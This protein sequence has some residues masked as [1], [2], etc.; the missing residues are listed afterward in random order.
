MVALPC[1]SATIDPF[2]Y[3][4]MP[5]II[6][7]DAKEFA[8][9]TFA[10]VVAAT[11]NLFPEGD[12]RAVKGS[13][14]PGWHW[15]E[16]NADG[17][18]TKPEFAERLFT[19]T[20]D[21]SHFE[22]Q[23]HNVLAM[24]A[25]DAARDG[26][27]VV[28]IV[29]NVDVNDAG[30]TQFMAALARGMQRGCEIGRFALLNGETA[31]L[32]YR[33][34]GIGKNRLNWNAV[35]LKLVNDEKVIDGNGLKPG[36]PVVALRETSIRSNGLT[37]ARAILERAHM[38]Q[39]EGTAD[40][41]IYIAETMRRNLGYALPE[42]RILQVL[43]NTPVGA[44][45]WEHIHLPWHRSFPDLTQKLSQPST[46][47]TPLIYEAQGG[48]DGERKIP[49]VACAHISGGGVP[50]KGK[51]MV[52]GKELGIHLEAVFPDPEGISELMA[53]A[54]KGAKHEERPL[55]DERSACEQWNRGIGFLCVTE[56]ME[57]AK[58]LLELAARMGYEAAVAGE[59]TTTRSI[60]WRGQQWTY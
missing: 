16:V 37:R 53:L 43:D 31:E 18:G 56:N 41:R 5:E 12:Y 50:L 24:V 23:A 33:T 52:E 17:I 25:D 13:V 21:Y 8:S 55:I 60:E 46:I 26:K 14:N 32:G 20:G 10:D 57:H 44:E 59:I 48:V 27:F 15:I 9:K 49:L 19:E 34:P 3:D 40:K 47:Y 29:N 11:A 42:H 51:R 45:L 54:T 4:A 36:Q 38:M 2:S 30:D 6:T 28:G 22:S 39:T 35:A 1:H 7:P 58:Q